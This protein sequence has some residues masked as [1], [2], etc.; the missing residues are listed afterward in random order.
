MEP[1]RN[2]CYRRVTFGYRREYVHRLVWEMHYGEIPSGMTIDHEDGNGLN[3]RLENLRLVPMAINAK[4][5]RCPITNTSGVSGVSWVG[6]AG[7]WRAYLRH[8][9]KQV[10]L[11]YFALKDE[12]AAAVRSARAAF[13]YHP[14]HGRA[15]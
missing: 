9:G 12:A 2:T 8:N 14:N 3:N 1:H 11:G 7:K 5:A 13:G 15:A 4:N 6:R 10:F